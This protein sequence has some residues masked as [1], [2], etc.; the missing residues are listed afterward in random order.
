[1]IST[2]FS[3]HLS[4]G[5]NPRVLSLRLSTTIYVLTSFLRFYNITYQ[6]ALKKVRKPKKAPV[7]VDRLP[8]I[9]DLQKMILSS[10]SLRLSMLIQLRAQIGMR[11]NEALNL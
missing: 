11:L 6:N 8:P 3:N 5:L 9:G 7:R 10:K 2:E 1:M 4:V